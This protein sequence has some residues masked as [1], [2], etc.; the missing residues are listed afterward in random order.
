MNLHIAN[1]GN[2][3]HNSEEKLRFTVALD[4]EHVYGY[5]SDKEHCDENRMFISLVGV[6]KINRDGRCNDFKGKYDEPLHGIVL[7]QLASFKQDRI[8]LVTHPIANP[9]AGSRNR[10]EYAEKEPD[11][12][13][14]TA[15]SP[16]ACTLTIYQLCST[17]L[18]LGNSN[19]YRT[20]KHKPNQCKAY[21]QRCRSA[22]RERFA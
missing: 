19:A 15:I 8:D 7:E 6:P 22:R 14:R 13:K 17:V 10:V 12:G 21:D 3:F 16:S 11:T 1:N 2:N 9:H 5:D 20:I 18:W 4:T